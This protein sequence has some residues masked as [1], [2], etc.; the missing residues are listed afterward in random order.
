MAKDK[1]SGCVRKHNQVE[2]NSHQVNLN[3]IPVT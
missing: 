1:K 2:Q 3:L